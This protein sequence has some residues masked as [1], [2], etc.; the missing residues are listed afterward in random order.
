[1]SGASITESFKAR[2]ETLIGDRGPKN[3][4]AV[5]W[6]EIDKIYAEARRQAAGAATL[7]A[8]IN[9]IIADAIGTSVSDA[10]SSSLSSV[11]QAIADME[12][13]VASINSA[14]ENIDTVTAQLT[15]NSAALTNYVDQTFAT[16]TQDIV[17]LNLN[18]DIAVQAAQDAE[19]ARSQSEAARDAA[20]AAQSATETARNQAQTSASN[21]SGSAQAAAG[22]ASTATTKAGEAGDSATAAAASA[23][24]AT[25]KAGQASTSATAAATSAT[26]ASTSAGAASTSAAAAETARQAAQTARA[27]A[28]AARDTSV[29]ASQ[30]ATES[31]STAATQAG[32]ATTAANNAG[33][34][35]QA[36]AGS[37]STAT[38]KASEAAQS[39][40]AANTSRTE[41][42]AGAATATTK[43]TEASTA[44]ATAG[45]HAAAAESARQ[46]SAQLMSQGQSVIT[47]QYLARNSSSGWTRGGPGPGSTVT[48]TPNEL[49]PIGQTWRFTLGA[50]EAKNLNTW[51]DRSI[52]T[53]QKTAE[54][55]VIE[56]EFDLEAGGLGGAG[57]RAIWY[58]SAG[59]NWTASKPLTSMVSNP[60][61]AGRMLA[62]GVF[63]RPSEFTGDL[64]RI[65][66]LFDANYSSGSIYGAR[67]AK[68]LAVHRIS[69]R[70]ATAEEIGSGEVGAQIAASIAANDLVVV[71]REQAIAQSV[72]ALESSMNDALDDKADSSAV[73]TLTT[74]VTNAEG[75]IS[76]MA[77]QISALSSDLSDLENLTT[78]NAD[79]VTGL[80]TRVDSA[81]GS[82]SALSTQQTTLSASVTG[83]Q[84]SVQGYQ[85]ALDQVSDV[86]AGAAVTVTLGPGAVGLPN[87]VQV[88]EGAVARDTTGLTNGASVKIPASVAALLG[89]QRIKIS[90]LAL[91]PL[92]NAATRFGV[93]YATNAD[94]DSGYM[95]ATED[96]S[97]TP[98][99]FSFYYTVPMPSAQRDHYIGLYGDA[100]KSGKATLFARVSVEIAAVAGEIP[101]IQTLDATVSDILAV[102]VDDLAGTALGTLLTQ[103]DVQANGTSATVAAQGTALA[104][105]EGNAAASYVLRVGAG[106]ASAG[107][108][109][110]AADNPISGAT[111]ALRV[112]ADN[113]LLDGTVATKKLIVTD[114]TN[115][116]PNPD[117]LFGEAEWFRKTGSVTFLTGENDAPVPTV[118]QLV[119]T[120]SVASITTH[121]NFNNASEAKDGIPVSAGD[122]FH[123]EAWVKSSVAAATWHICLVERAALTGAVR[124]IVPSGS[125]P[126]IAADV[127]TKITGVVTAQSS[128]T[129]FFQCRNPVKNSTL[130]VTKLRLVKQSGGELLVDG[131]I[132]ARE[133][134]A[135]EITAELVNAGSFYSAGL[136]VF[137]GTLQSANF[138]D[139][140]GTGWILQQDGTL[141]VPNANIGTLKIAG[142]AVIQPFGAVIV[143]SSSLEVVA[144]TTITG[145]AA[146]ETCDVMITTTTIGDNGSFGVYVGTSLGSMTLISNDNINLTVANRVTAGN[147]PLYVKL[148]AITGPTT[149]PRRLSIQAMG[150]KR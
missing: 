133:I 55:Y 83:L 130:K 120:T 79:A 138:N 14:I 141:R 49:Y 41:A 56:A 3:K 127:W 76:T 60:Q 125:A 136:S 123:V 44:A 37:A 47:D 147:G 104:D 58:N 90:V 1:M 10:V 34:S 116:I 96:T 71:G 36:A 148:A 100:A 84:A 98:K 2:L 13:E 51:S 7:P 110:V 107:L 64:D 35:A 139:G 111:S 106:G 137:G 73:S 102:K 103:L 72:T 39:A 32:I 129:V 93:A 114:T 117:F 105:L 87:T 86:A 62:R 119:R 135:G 131:A 45:G 52:W 91:R 145:L 24:T 11:D 121:G 80:A 68:T 69:I 124:V 23:V 42:A 140:A 19:D 94:G 92:S 149:G 9:Q 67:V 109:L 50:S 113:I 128:G 115:L 12:A 31:A 48:R 46:I 75:T 57:V 38:T 5:L 53:G 16:L 126:S 17:D 88:A 54:A 99:W 61:P 18:Y 146:G 59:S 25:N 108:E 112:N 30:T 26:S 29:T 144:S 82:I 40:S 85:V 101:A 97:T 150:I 21:A 8:N 43:A 33:G 134:R 22:S 122:K 143:D 118:A 27:G 20:A 142:Q 66:V 70:V 78:A 28:E 4:T 15:Q 65:N 6:S 89:G 77:G 74:R 81:E 95:E 63:R 132:T